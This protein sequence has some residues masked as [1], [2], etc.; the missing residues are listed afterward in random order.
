VSSF[1]WE[2]NGTDSIL[3]GVG[4]KVFLI[5]KKLKFFEVKPGVLS[6][7]F[8]LKKKRKKSWNWCGIRGF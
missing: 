8:L 6:N 2:L 4:L 5:K 3:T 1:F 7:N